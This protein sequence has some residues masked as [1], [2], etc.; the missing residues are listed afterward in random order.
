L[1][2]LHK[3]ALENGKKAVEL[4]G[5]SP[6]MKAGLAF[7]HALAGEIEKA[8]EI[9]D[10]MIA[11]VKS[12]QMYQGALATVYV[13]LKEKDLAM[14]CLEAVYEQ[15]EAMM[16]IIRAWYEDYLGTDLLSDDPRFNEMQKKI[17]L[18]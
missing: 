4:S 9:R 12:G 6:F 5:G 16:Y 8:K 10:E 15:N 13:G 1:K 7:S 14:E 11:L 17:G 2:G 3:E 18:E